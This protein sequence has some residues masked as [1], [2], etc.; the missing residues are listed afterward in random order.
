MPRQ[1]LCVG[2]I[3]PGSSQ[4]GPARQLAHPSEPVITGADNATNPHSGHKSGDP[5]IQAS[6]WGGWEGKL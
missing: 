6:S 5:V 3:P 4:G 2:P 1:A